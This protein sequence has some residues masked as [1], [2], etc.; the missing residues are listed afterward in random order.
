MSISLKRGRFF[1]ENDRD[2]TELVTIIDETLAKRYWPNEDPIGQRIRLGPPNNPSFKIVGIVGHVAHPDVLNDAGTGVY[3]LSLLQGERSGSAGIIVKISGD[4]TALVGVIREAV[5]A[6]APAE[7]VHSVNSMEDYISSTLS[8][9]R[10]GMR[11]L[12]FFAATALFLTALGLYG[13]IS[14]SVTQRTREI[15]VRMALGAK[16]ATVL[17]L[18]VGQGFRLTAVGVAFGSGAAI[19]VGRLLESELFQVKASDP[20]TMLSMAA[21]LLLTGLLA[22]YLPARRA[23]RVDPVVTLRHE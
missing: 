10:F 12:G 22:S 19:W 16:P 23:I 15:G 21:A 17:K 4:P 7:A 20:L 18:V 1:S 14:Y 8:T 13:V 2:K 6:V 9:R 3:Y 11:L 5:R